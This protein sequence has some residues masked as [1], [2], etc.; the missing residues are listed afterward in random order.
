[1]SDD[2]FLGRIFWSRRYRRGE[3]KNVGVV[4]EVK[5]A[6]FDRVG[7]TTQS[8]CT[9]LVAL[10]KRVCVMPN[11]ETGCRRIQKIPQANFGG[12]VFQFVQNVLSR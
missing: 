2:S 8:R 7:C 12:P 4:K 6:S 9:N 11:A 1:M 3:L 5:I 10:Y